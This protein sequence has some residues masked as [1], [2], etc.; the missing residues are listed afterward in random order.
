M[1]RGTLLLES[2][3]LAVFRH[4]EGAP[5]CVPAAPPHFAALTVRAQLPRLSE[6]LLK[7]R[8]CQFGDAL[9]RSMLFGPSKAEVQ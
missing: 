3:Q 1:G 7:E 8:P 4:L 9:L 2:L 6:P 5:L